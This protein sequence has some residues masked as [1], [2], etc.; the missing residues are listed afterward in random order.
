MRDGYWLARGGKTL[1]RPSVRPGHGGAKCDEF[2]FCKHV[3]DLEVQVGE[4]GTQ[5]GDHRFEVRGKVCS[6]GFLVVNAV[7]SQSSLDDGEIPFIEGMLHKV[8][9]EGFV[10]V[11]C[12][13]FSPLIVVQLYSITI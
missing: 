1:K 3:V 13:S 8:P 5:H 2:S 7:L 4:S 11:G 6:Q 12:H 10:G 9:D